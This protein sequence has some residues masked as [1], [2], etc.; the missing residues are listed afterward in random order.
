[1]LA[2]TMKDEALARIAARQ[3]ALVTTKD[4]YRLG[5]TLDDFEHRSSVGRLQVV[6]R[7]VRRIAGTNPT[8]EQCVLAACLAAGHGAVAS[9][10]TAACLLGFVKA[11]RPDR[12]DITVA[13]PAHPRLS[14]V[15]T[16]RVPVLDRSDVTMIAGIA[17]TSVPRTV[18]DVASLLPA[19]RL[20][21]IVNDL[22]RRKLLTVR[23]LAAAADR[24]E[25]SG[26]RRRLAV[27]RK[28]IDAKGEGFHPGDSDPEVWVVE[29]LVKAGLGRPIQQ[30]K[31]RVR[32]NDYRLDA[33][34]PEYKVAVEY[35]GEE[36]HALPGDLQRDR[37]RINTLTAAGW[38]IRFATKDTSARA[39]VDDVRAALR[40]A[41]A[42]G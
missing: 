8:W 7:G 10:L 23:A 36:G 37:H 16:H 13:A 14:G 40:R 11:G 30:F 42:T 39:L 25:V 32:G 33:A 22:L 29:T 20:D 9:H 34:Y 6:R 17:V 15:K 5:M 41:G 31:V 3:R 2:M 12:I 35:E 4:A 19:R 1:M 27:V 26:T 24:V 28:I 38:D 18:I 21:A